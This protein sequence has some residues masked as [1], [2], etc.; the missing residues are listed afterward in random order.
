MHVSE[1]QDVQP[2]P[3]ASSHLLQPSILPDGVNNV[4]K[5]LKK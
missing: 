3:Y 4:E 5:L 2:N 1:L